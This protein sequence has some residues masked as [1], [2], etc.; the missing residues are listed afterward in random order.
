MDAHDPE[1]QHQES[2]VTVDSWMN[3]TARLKMHQSQQA[4]YLITLCQPSLL[5]YTTSDDIMRQMITPYK[6]LQA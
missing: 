6:Q 1:T 3:K 4:S 2:H 5:I